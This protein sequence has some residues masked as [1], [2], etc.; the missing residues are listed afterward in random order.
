MGAEYR[1]DRTFNLEFNGDQ[2]PSCSWRSRGRGLGHK[3][4]SL[5]LSDQI[6]KKSKNLPDCS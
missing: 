5:D 4:G 6:D 1:G 3:E 2:S